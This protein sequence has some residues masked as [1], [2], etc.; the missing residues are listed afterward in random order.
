MDARKMLDRRKHPFYQHSE[1]AFLLAEEGGKDVGRLA[2]LDNRHYNEYNRS[3]C[4]FFYL[5]ECQPNEAAGQALFEAAFDWARER[6]LDEISG[7]K[8][9]S[10]LDGMGLLVKG[11]EHRPALGIPYHLAYYGEM[12][13]KAGFERV[14]DIVSG[15][16]DR[17]F[18]LP[19]KVFRAAKAVEERMGLRVMR[20]RSRAE[21]R[22]IVPRLKDLYNNAL[23]GTT[24]ST[25]LTEDEARS[26]ADQI[27]WFA[28]PRL[29]KLI[30][31]GDDLAGFLFAYPDISAAIQRTRGRLWPLG[32]ADM[33]LELRRTKWFN[34]NGAGILP[35]YRGMG[36]TALLFR[37]AV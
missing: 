5:F 30:F 26:M 14:E 19:E 18:R 16:V 4:A 13:E 17:S 32:W 3:N 8:G 37:R 22:R 11:F 2:V 24:G 31:K 27:L 28:D 9:L 15:R 35:R 21:L 34:V 25:P 23:E 7:P 20:F 6:G 36:A 29:I 33:L 10:T 1:A 12:V